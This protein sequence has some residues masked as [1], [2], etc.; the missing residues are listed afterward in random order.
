MQFMDIKFLAP[1]EIWE[2]FDPAKD[3]LET[4]IISQDVVD[5]I[6]KSKQ[7]FSVEENGNESLRAY[8]EIYY[9]K[10]WADDR[11]AV[12]FLSSIKINEFEAVARNVVKEG[13]V[14]CI[15]DYC[16]SFK[17][18]EEKTKFPP[19]L[20]FASYPECKKHLTTI[21]TDAKHTPW[22]VWTKIA[23]RAITLLSEQ[24]CVAKD[25]IGIIGSE[26][27]AQVAWITSGV[28]KRVNALVAVNGG[29]YLWAIDSP[30]SL[31]GNVPSTDEATAFSSGIGA[32]TYAK[33]VECPTLLIA[34]SN[35]TYYD[36][37]RAGDILDNVKC[38]AKQ[39]IISQGTDAQ[40][41][42]KTFD[43]MMLWLRNNLGFTNSLDY[44]PTISF[45]VIEHKLYARV[46]T[47]KKSS[48]RALYVSYG[49]PYSYARVWEKVTDDLK[50]EKHNYKWFIPV[51]DPSKI[52]VVY[53]DIDYPNGN[54]MSTRLISTLPVK[55]GVIGEELKENPQDRI[56][57]DNSMGIGPFTIVTSSPI[58]ND[59]SLKVIAGPSKIKGVSTDDG[60]LYVRH[61]AKDMKQVTR[62]ALLHFDVYSKTERDLNLIMYSYPN[63]KKYSATVHL[64][65]GEYWQNIILNSEDFKGEDGRPLLDYNETKLF[66]INDAKGLIFNN[67][68]WI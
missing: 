57:Y 20:A 30:K 37:D 24:K 41:T 43:N 27:G 50:V 13:Y 40:I 32:E 63:R 62:I 11:P 52:V 29:G 34:S 4:S 58:L 14:A 12:M 56:F 25:K 39:L 18:E 55:Q 2:T 6:V 26:W 16:G 64:T 8:I 60:S 65:G 36:L 28:D 45:E 19:S 38:E 35:S 54:T 67:F 22:Y 44:Y 59:D 46:D 47:A 31:Y 49:E 33:M 3:S 21:E 7:Y 5:N 17:N 66:S 23:R 51:E 48:A 61:N 15:V 10:R 9:D 68:L 53:A 42:N 1:T